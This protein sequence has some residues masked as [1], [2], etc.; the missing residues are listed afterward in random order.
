MIHRSES[1]IAFALGGLG[2]NNAH[3]GGFLQAALETDVRPLMISCTSGQ[4]RWVCEYLKALKAGTSNLRQILEED[5]AETHPFGVKYLDMLTLMLCGLP[6]RFHPAWSGFFFDYLENAVTTLHRAFRAHFDVVPGVEE[7]RTFPCRLAVP[8]FI[9]SFSAEASKLFRESEIGIVCNSFN[10]VAGIENVYLND[11]AR[12]LLSNRRRGNQQQYAPGQPSRYRPRTRYAEITPDAIRDALWLYNY[13][14]DPEDRPRAHELFLDGSYF[15]M[16]L[17]NEL[18]PV[19]RIYVA[20]PINYRWFGTLPT[21]WADLE[22][23]KTKL[24]FNRAYEG[25]RDQILLV[26]KLVQ[27]QVLQA[28][29][30]ATAGNG[31]DRGEDG[32]YHRIDLVEVEIQQQRGYLDYAFEDLSVFDDAHALALEAFRKHEGLNVTPVMREL[33][34]PMP[35]LEA[36][37]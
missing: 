12:N 9:E 28:P 30:S 27:D 23:L 3:G 29:G 34:A 31:Q 35:L 15:R 32:F 8:D 1:S 7:L 33:H 25:E 14:F 5:V 26:N 18:T 10:P 16:I 37:H 6:K 17:L 22:D 20:R 2:G 4:T 21:S 19:R 11:A 13:G 36:V 24:T